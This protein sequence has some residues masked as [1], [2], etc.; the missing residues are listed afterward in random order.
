MGMSEELNREIL[1]ELKGINQKLDK[2]DER[3]GISTPLKFLAV[4]IGGLIV[5]PLCMVIIGV[6][7]RFL[8]ID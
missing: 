3:R 1:D 6:I 4:I 5:G 7:S 2:I 8:N